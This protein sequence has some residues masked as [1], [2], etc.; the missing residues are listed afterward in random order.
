[1]QIREGIG[2]EFRAQAAEVYW[3]AFRDKLFFALGPDDRGQAY[4]ER[5]MRSDRAFIAY[6][7]DEVLGIAG[8]DIG[9]GGLIQERF[10]DFFGLYG[11]GALWRMTLLSVFARQRMPGTLQIDGIAVASQHRSKGI[12]SALMQALEEKARSVNC[13]NMALDVINTNGRARALYERMGFEA[14][15][16]YNLYFLS[17]FFN[18]Q[19]ATHM[20]KALD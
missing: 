2:E 16:S 10:L 11:V 19:S 14:M 18:F 6:E 15:R 4:F 8:F 17:R 9:N 5:A 20:V 12:G 13:H 1:M 3:L 7:G